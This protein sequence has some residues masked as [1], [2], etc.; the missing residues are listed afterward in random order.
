M[1][2]WEMRR[3]DTAPGRQPAWQTGD[4]ACGMLLFRYPN[5]IPPP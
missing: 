3:K 1:F 5:S 2:W 4:N